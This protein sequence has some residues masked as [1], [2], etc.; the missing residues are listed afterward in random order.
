M[1]NPKG[2]CVTITDIANRHKEWIKIAVYCGCPAQLV[3]DIVQDMYYK[4]CKIDKEEGNLCRISY[5]GNVNMV[6]MFSMISNAITSEH[7]KKKHLDFIEEMHDL[8]VEDKFNEAPYHNLVNE[9]NETM[10]EM[11]WYDRQLFLLYVNSG[12]SMRRIA[13]ETGISLTSINNTIQNVKRTIQ[14][15]HENRYK[16]TKKKG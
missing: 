16:E 7:R 2:L 4:L 5:N 13:S 6:Y 8:P 10:L 1:K 11:H 15:E 9:I 14:E 12:K 3:D